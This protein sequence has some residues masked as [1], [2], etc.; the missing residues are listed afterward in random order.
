MVNVEKCWEILKPA[1]RT[2][3]QHTT[4]SSPMCLS[5]WKLVPI[6]PALRFTCCLS[7]RSINFIDTPVSTWWIDWILSGDATTDLMK[8]V[9]NETMQ[10]GENILV[11]K[12]TLITYYFSV[13]SYFCQLCVHHSVKKVLPSWHLDLS[14]TQAVWLAEQQSRGLQCW[15]V[16][17]LW[18]ISLVYWMVSNSGELIVGHLKV[19]KLFY[20]TDRYK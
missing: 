18:R 7:L 14:Y 13:L 11:Y 2:C 16:V 19:L 4:N 15:K 6:L 17:L 12:S 9:E 20:N 3:I 1:W 5:C 10:T 8:L